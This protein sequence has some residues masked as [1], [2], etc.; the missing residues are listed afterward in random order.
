MIKKTL[1][2]ILFMAHVC[3]IFGQDNKQVA[4]KIIA[5]VGNEIILESD[6]AKKMQNFTTDTIPESTMRCR[7]LSS[8]IEKKLLLTKAREDSVRVKNQ[9]I[10]NELNRRMQFFINK[11]GSKSKLEEY[12][13]KSIPE[14]KEQMRQPTRELLLT[15]K[16]KNQVLADVEVTPKEV[17]Q[18]FE[19][20]PEDSIP[21]FNTQVKLGHIVRTPKPTEKAKRK[22][23]KDLRELR[24]RIVN[25]GESF[26]NL[27]I[28]YS[29]DESTATSGGDMGMRNKE[30]LNDK[31]AARAINLPRD[32]VSGVI[33]TE[34]G[35]HIVKLL[36]RKGDK[37]HLKHI[38]KKPQITPQSRSN[39]GKFLDSVRN[40]ILN[41]TLTFEQAA[42]KFSEDDKTKRNGGLILNKRTGS[43]KLPVEQLNSE[44]FFNIDT[45]EV[46]TISNPV[47]INYQGTQ[48]AYRIV[49]LKD[50]TEPHKANLQQDYPRIRRM[51]EQKAKQEALK[52]WYREYSRQTYIKLKADNMNCKAL[53]PYLTNQ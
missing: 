24:D 32:T 37:I 35:Y 52:G 23:K 6:L 8:S 13:D 20:L 25:D 26:D 31:L 27:A 44:M 53:S 10:E 33:K 17:R 34:K 43:N 3:F 38:L 12:Y 42:F 28:L 36:D 22:A 1:I 21:D 30:T 47:P 46:G 5:I 41:D 51:A 39:A 18:Y 40:L 50:K 2:T 45:M 49:Y 16:M 4:D 14:I 19:N 48:N 7:V 15:E 11:V 29:D 9:R